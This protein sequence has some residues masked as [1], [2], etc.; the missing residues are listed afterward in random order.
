M[1]SKT[2]V[3]FVRDY[4]EYEPQSYSGRGMYGKSCVGITCD[5]PSDVVLDII[6]AQA[7]NDPTEVSELI[8]ML[9]R[10][11]QDSMGRSAIIYW[12]KIE[13]PAD[14]EEVDDDEESEPCPHGVVDDFC[15]K[16]N[17]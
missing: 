6:Q 3:E 8:D 7:E 17:G 4:T 12:P 5:N 11:S 15:I 14:E 1:D 9:R 16:C 2:F 13:W 10:S